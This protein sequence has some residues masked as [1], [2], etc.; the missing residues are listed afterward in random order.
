VPIFGAKSAQ[1]AQQ[2]SSS[3]QMTRD[4]SMLG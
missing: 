3:D 2:A 1:Q 4:A